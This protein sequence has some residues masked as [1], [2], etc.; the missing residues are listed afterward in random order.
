VPAERAGTM[1]SLFLLLLIPLACQP[2]QP[3]EQCDK[4]TTKPVSCEMHEVGDQLIFQYSEDI[5]APTGVTC[6]SLGGGV[7]LCPKT[8]CNVVYYPGNCAECPVSQ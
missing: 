6:E 7:Y 4:E 1:K 5:P 3:S 2:A 8:F